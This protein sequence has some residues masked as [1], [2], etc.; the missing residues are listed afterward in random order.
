[1]CEP[2]DAKNI[3]VEIKNARATLIRA[4]EKVF[5]FSLYRSIHEADAGVGSNLRLPLNDEWMEF[6][7]CLAACAKAFVDYLNE[8]QI[9]QAAQADLVVF[10]AA[11]PGREVRG[12]DKLEVWLGSVGADADILEGVKS[13]RLVQL[14][15]SRSS[16]HGKSSG[17]FDLI[18]EKG[19]N[20]TKPRETLRKLVLVPLVEFC[21]KLTCFVETKKTA[22]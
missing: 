20:P 7:A 21:H 8:K 17:F 9:E 10:R 19:G 6:D 1:M 11:N 15:R 4:T 2:A 3:D 18:K 5:G 16:A 22:P 12:I 14:L 13:L